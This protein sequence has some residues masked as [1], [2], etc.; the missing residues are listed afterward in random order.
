LTLAPVS[1]AK[2][3]LTGPNFVVKAIILA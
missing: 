2:D 3:A 1:T